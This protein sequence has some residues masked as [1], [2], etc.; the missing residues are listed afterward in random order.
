MA[1]KYTGKDQILVFNAF[2][3]GTSGACVTSAD[4][5][6]SADVYKAAC[7]GAGTK[8]TVVGQIDHVITFNLLVDTAAMDAVFNETAGDATLFP[9]AFDTDFS[10]KPEG[11]TA[12]DP[13]V[14]AA[15]G[16][17]GNVTVGVPVEGLVNAT[18]EIHLETPAMAANI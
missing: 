16:V 2:T 10:W 13:V 11:A 7:A 15:R 8:A 5:N 1:A 14:T 3:A 18:V 17:I 9:G 12:G 6:M 4:W